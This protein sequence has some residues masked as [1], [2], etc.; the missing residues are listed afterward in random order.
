MRV[1]SGPLPENYTRADASSFLEA[2]VLGTTFGGFDANSFS[3]ALSF[4]ASQTDAPTEKRGLLWFERGAGQ[5]RFLDDPDRSDSRYSASQYCRICPTREI[6]VEPCRV[7]LHAAASTYNPAGG[8]LMPRFAPTAEVLF[9]YFRD[10]QRRQTVKVDPYA[11]AQ[12][13]AMSWPFI[14]AETSSSGVPVRAVEFGYCTVYMAS[15]VTDT[16]GEH[17]SFSRA[18]SLSD[19]S[20][21]QPFLHCRF[22][23]WSGETLAFKVGV[24]AYSSGATGLHTNVAFKRPVIDFFW[25]Q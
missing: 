3:T 14:A 21:E 18:A 22:N 15:G 25:D 2:W 9:S 23:A 11:S 20:Q 4:V 10:S 7:G 1:T 12:V 24:L 16:V 19:A 13:R 6:L 5:L 17:L 8:I